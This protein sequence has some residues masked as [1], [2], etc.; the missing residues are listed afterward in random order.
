MKKTLQYINAASLNVKG[1]Y[2]LESNNKFVFMEKYKEMVYS[3]T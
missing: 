2:Y 1:F 3:I